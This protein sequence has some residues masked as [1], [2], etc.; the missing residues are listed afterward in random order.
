MARPRSIKP[1]ASDIQGTCVTCGEHPQ[2]PRGGGKFKA[3]CNKCI[4]AKYHAGS[5]GRDRHLYRTYGIT[6]SDYQAMYA[7]QGGVCRICGEGQ[8]HT[9]FK[10]L[11]VDHCHRTGRV[12]GLLCSACNTSI[13]LMQESETRLEN[14]IKYLREHCQ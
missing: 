10:A 8:S 5:K 7:A 2:A 3:H 11:C 14:A 1:E 9:R 12:R 13:G 4:T 6:D